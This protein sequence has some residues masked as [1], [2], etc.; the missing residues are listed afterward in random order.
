MA[1]S[2]LARTVRTVRHLTAEQWLFRAVC[3]GKRMTM[4]YAPDRAMRRTRALADALPLP[5]P[6]GLPLRRVAGHVLTLQQAVHGQT[7]DGIPDGRFT[8]LNRTVDFG[9][10]DRVEWRRDLGEANNPLWR[11]NLAYFGWA[12][13]LLALGEADAEA[14]QLVRRMLDS[15]VVQNPFQVPGV[16]RDVWNAYTASHRCINLITGL[17][18]HLAAGGRPEPEVQYAILDHARLCA[19]FVLRNL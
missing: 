11:M 7:L 9:G 6:P 2:R 17:S 13:P 3:R 12:V 5:H 18:L 15:L 1:L 4:R 10:I 8:F 14:A 16:F 19:A